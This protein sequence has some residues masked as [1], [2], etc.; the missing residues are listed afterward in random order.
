[1]TSTDRKKY[2]RRLLQSFDS[3]NRRELPNFFEQLG[4]ILWLEFDWDVNGVRSSVDESKVILVIRPE[5]YATSLLKLYSPAAC[6]I[7]K[8]SVVAGC[9]ME[10]RA[11]NSD[12]ETGKI[13]WGRIYCSK[14]SCKR[15][16][17]STSQSFH[18][19]ESAPCYVWHLTED[20]S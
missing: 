5:R 11:W 3:R 20:L 12:L 2:S 13:S 15:H 7:C 10:G 19:P 16:W 9:L 17:T 18:C 8:D 4:E 1:V 6:S 14:P